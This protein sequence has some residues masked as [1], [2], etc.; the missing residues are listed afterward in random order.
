MI[1]L[2]KVRTASVADR[3][4][5]LQ[6]QFPSL[7][8]FQADGTDVSDAGLVHLSKLTNLRKLLLARTR[9]TDAG[10]VHLRGLTNLMELSI[11][12]TDVTDAGLAHLKGLTN[13]RELSIDDGHVTDAGVAELRRALPRLQ[14]RVWPSLTNTRI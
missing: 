3:V 7:E 2:R 10:L 13:L 14:V 1:D 12:N 8:E 9:V 6:W 4:C 5:E 11:D